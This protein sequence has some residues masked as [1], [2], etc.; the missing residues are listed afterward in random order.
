MR[1]RLYVRP[2]LKPVLDAPIDPKPE[3][4]PENEL[5]VDIVHRAVRRL[6]EEGA[7]PSVR[8]INLSVCDSWRPF[9]NQMSPWA[10][11]L[12]YL[13]WRYRVLFIISAGNHAAPIA[14]AVH[15]DQFPGVAAVPE[16][17]ERACYKA[18]Y[19][20][21]RNRRLLSPSESINALT[22]AS[23]HADSSLPPAARDRYDL[24]RMIGLPSL[25]NAHGLGFRRSVKPDVLFPGGRALYM[26]RIG[27]NPAQTVLEILDLAA[28]PGQRVAAPGAAGI[29]D[30]THYSRGT[31]N[32][33]AL[34]TRAAAQVYENLK[35]LQISVGGDRLPEQYLHLLVKALIIHGARWGNS[36]DA[37]RQYLDAPDK[38]K[39]TRLLG[40]GV[41]DVERVVGCTDQR[42]TLLGSGALAAGEAHEYK[43]PLPPSLS[44]RRSWRRLIV[45]LAWCTSTNPRHRSYRNADMWFV[46]RGESGD[47]DASQLLRVNRAEVDG[48]TVLRGTLQHE[49]FEGSQA[50]AFRDGD[51][52]KVLV[53]CREDAGRVREP[54]P[55]GL[56]VTL[57]VAPEEPI[58]VYE[59]VEARIRPRVIVRQ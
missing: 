3:R 12:D 44:G 24:L 19:D 10:R 9:Y 7:A 30:A 13:S 52:V 15:H 35:G 37:L 18:V 22:V 2:I 11:L 58:A 54:V 14:L 29:L 23:V 45:T 27:G 51:A 33:A 36:A 17:L 16:Q 1:R 20:D 38:D 48:Q 28:P 50:T 32:A 25:V 47:G 21:T 4:V 26:Q 46:T 56:A 42:V 39:V 6:F 57:E 8:I 55:Y 59:Q 43:I 49:L 53:N 31:S 5:P 41:A 40:Y 34:A